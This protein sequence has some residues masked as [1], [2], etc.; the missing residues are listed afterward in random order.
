MK[1]IN[2]FG[3]SE[4]IKELG[5]AKLDRLLALKTDSLGINQFPIYH[6]NVDFWLFNDQ[7]MVEKIEKEN[8][9]KNQKIISSRW[10]HLVFKDKNWNIHELYERNEIENDVNN[11]GWLALWWAVKEGYTHINLYGIMDGKYVERSDGNVL[12]YN[13]F[14]GEH[15]MSAQVYN[16]LLK[17]IESGF[18]KR[19]KICRPLLEFSDAQIK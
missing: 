6:P 2:I 16:R 10:A 14:A 4:K 7:C 9:Y 13:M 3:T 8:A 19:A 12:Y 1:K 15:I 5:A 17:D 18:N 11:S